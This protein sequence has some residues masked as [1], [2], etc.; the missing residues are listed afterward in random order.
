M[1]EAAPAAGPGDAPN[2]SSVLSAL[3]A[4]RL[5]DLCRLF[6]CDVHDGLAPAGR[7]DRLVH[8]LSSALGQRLPAILR[9]LG[10]DELRAVCRRHALDATLRPRADL[11]AVILRAAGLDPNAT[12]ARPPAPI[13]DGLPSKGQ[14]VHARHR[15]WL[16]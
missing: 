13:I 9:E 2:T 7:K 1:F 8:K 10:R 12:S 4:E 3:S 11:Q 6:G 14:V 5:L 15:Q 16:V